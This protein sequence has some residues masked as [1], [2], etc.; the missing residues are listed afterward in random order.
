MGMPFVDNVS[1]IL[2]LIVE[3]FNTVIFDFT[4]TSSGEAF[5]VTIW[6]LTIFGVV[7]SVALHFLL[8]TPSN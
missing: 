6:D 4:I 8:P 7:M 3:V 2:S 5:Q 1:V